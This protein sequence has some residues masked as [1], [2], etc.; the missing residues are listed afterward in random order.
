MTTSSSF[1]ASSEKKPLIL[2]VDD[3]PKNLQVLGTILRNESYEVAAATSGTQALE[4]L[5][6]TLPDLILLDVMMPG[7]NGL[8]VCRILKNDEATA[9]IPVIFL[10]AKSEM[11]DLVEGFDAGAADYLTKPFQAKELLARVRTQLSVKKS[12]DLIEQY[13]WQLKKNAREL[14]QLNNEKNELLEIVAH[15]LKN[16]LSTIQ[17]AARKIQAGTQAMQQDD[18]RSQAQLI[19]QASERM[20]RLIKNLL[21]VNAIESGKMYLNREP[22]NLSALIAG[23]GQEYQSKAA[24]K[25]I[26]LHYECVSDALCA[27]T[28]RNAVRQILDNLLSNAI[29]YSP[30]QRAVWLSASAHTDWV[31]VSVR[32]QGPGL[33]EEDVQKLFGKFVRLTPKPTGGESSTGLGLAI[34]KKLVEKAGG[35]IWCESVL[36]QGSTFSVELPKQ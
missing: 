10:T 20:F 26:K 22:V 35:R 32:D 8:D 1:K 27:F 12:Q 21:D 19:E 33:C 31:Q 13:V 36:G 29:K 25:Q 14:K 17:H 24:A 30:P 7:M 28:D 34:A 9:A 23:M 2:I 4:I 15:D 11:E 5:E 3:G 6:S 18:I 16:P